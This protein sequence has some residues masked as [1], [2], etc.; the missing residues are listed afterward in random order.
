MAKTNTGALGPYHLH[1]VFSI[2]VG[3]EWIPS[4]YVT[5]W[6]VAADAG[7]MDGLGLVLRGEPLQSSGLPALAEVWHRLAKMGEL[8]QREHVG[9]VGA[10]LC[11]WKRLRAEAS[12]SSFDSRL[13]ETVDWW[14]R[15]LADLRNADLLLPGW[16]KDA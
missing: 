15:D 8:K 2:A 7:T 14:D 1:M 4:R 5:W 3:A 10:Q 11:F 9:S 16:H 12:G 13:E 6:P